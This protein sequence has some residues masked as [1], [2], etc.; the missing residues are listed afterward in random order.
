[1]LIVEKAG[2][3]P[4]EKAL[5]ITTLKQIRSSSNVT[6]ERGIL[7][8]IFPS[9]CDVAAK[10]HLSSFFFLW[11]S[12]FVLDTLC[13]HMRRCSRNST[14]SLQEQLV[15]QRCGHFHHLFPK[16]VAEGT[17]AGPDGSLETNELV[18]QSAEYQLVACSSVSNMRTFLHDIVTN[19][20]NT[21][22][23]DLWFKQNQEVESKSDG[24]FHNFLFI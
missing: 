13:P 16:V 5:W 3:L 11:P 20:K 24:Q 23:L 17:Q 9:S 4:E 6:N 14:F 12:E 1:M 10:S 7:F 8:V 15:S 18:S 21:F 19:K 22:I 2:I